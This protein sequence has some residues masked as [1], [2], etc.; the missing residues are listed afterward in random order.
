M[1]RYSVAVDRKIRKRKKKKM[2]KMRHLVARNEC[3]RAN[4]K[5]S[6]HDWKTFL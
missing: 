4:Y 6:R 3:V 1:T 5:Q 2:S